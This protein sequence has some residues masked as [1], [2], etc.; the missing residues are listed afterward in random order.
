VAGLVEVFG[1]A[2]R[3][4][5]VRDRLPGS[6]AGRA[7]KEAFVIVSILHRQIFFELARIFLLSLFG[8]TGI[9]VMAGLVAEATQQGLGP[10]QVIMVIPLLI[11]N[12]LPYTIPATTLF[13][14]CLVYG[15]LAHDNEILAIKSAGVNVLYVVWP[16]IILGL[17][18]SCVT[19][20]MYIELIPSTFQMLRAQIMKDVE[21]YM[22]ALLKK[23]CY[24]KQPGMNYSIFVKQVQGRRLID[25]VFKR[26]D[27]K[28]NYDVI[29]TAREAYLFVDTLT[30]DNGDEKKQLRVK[31]FHCQ[32]FGND[33]KEDHGYFA[34]K[35]WMVDLAPEL[36]GVSK[37]ARPRAL[38]WPEL[39][40]RRDELAEEAN[41]AAAELAEVMVKYNFS[42]PPDT[43]HQHIANLKNLVK[44]KSL[45]C[46]CVQAEMH[47]RP[48]ISFGCFFFVLVGCPVGIWFSRS[49][50]LSAF[51]TC[52][53]PI[54]FIY[55]PLLLCTNNLAKD[56]KLPPIVSLWIAN[57]ALGLI[58]PYLFYN[59]LKR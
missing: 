46:R 20:C 16:G 11:P 59:L 15:R 12:T 13:A 50:Y 25:A 28:G 4:D 5:Y 44:H 30:D 47:M 21:E 49:D 26:Q 45:E 56:G 23:D 14:T 38:T 54:V 18:M 31:M 39:A 9:L 8:I 43:M 22:Y 40:E 33:Q 48:A 55:Y 6:P 27:A 17:I 35:E 41:A 24:I 51:I 29:A 7:M 19:M 52:F 3:C 2:G 37:K 32:V 36:G 1:R 53:L 57:A 10:T 58:A 42:N 34:E